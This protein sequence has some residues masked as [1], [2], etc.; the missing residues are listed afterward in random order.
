MKSKRTPHNV[1]HIL[2]LTFFSISF[3]LANAASNPSLSFSCDNLTYGGEIGHDH[4][5]CY[6]GDTPQEL[7][8]LSL[9]SGGSGEIEY[10]WIMTTE[11]PNEFISNW[12]SI[13]GSIHENYQPEAIYET[14]WF[15]RCAR[16]STCNEYIVES[17]WV[18]VCIDSEPPNFLYLPE[19]YITHCNE[20]P[21]FSEPEYYD[22]CSGI[23]GATHFDEVVNRGCEVDYT[24][25]WIVTD[26]CGK[27]NVTSQTV[28]TI[29][30]ES[31]NITLLPPYGDFINGDTLIYE[32]SFGIFFYV[33]DVLVT[34][35]CDADPEVTFIDN[36]TE[37]ENCAEDGY[38]RFLECYWVA[39]D[40]CG[41]ESK[42]VLYIYEVDTQDPVFT[43]I[44][45]DDEIECHQDPIFGTPEYED[46]C[47]LTLH[48][49]ENVVS[50]GDNCNYTHTKTWTVT[51]DCG[52]HSTAQQSI[53]TYDNEAPLITLSDPFQEVA[54]GDTLILQCYQLQDI[55]DLEATAVDNCD[56]DPEIKF[57]DNFHE[58]DDCAEDGYIMKMYCTWTAIDDCGNES[59]LSIHIYIVDTEA[60]VFSSIPDDTTIDCN[61]DPAFVEP[62]V[63]DDCDDDVH[64][65]E[66]TKMVEVNCKFKYQRTWTATDDCGNSSRVIQSIYFSDE[67]PPEILELLPVLGEHCGEFEIQYPVVSDH[68][69]GTPEIYASIDTI[70][71]DLFIDLKINWTVMDDCGNE[72]HAYQ[73]VTLPCGDDFEFTGFEATEMSGNRVSLHWVVT[74]EDEASFYNVEVSKDGI[75]FNSTNHTFEARGESYLGFGAYAVELND[76]YNGR[77]FYRIKYLPASS[78]SVLSEM[79]QVIFDFNNNSIIYPNPFV[80]NI[81]IEFH[82][83]S[84]QASTIYL[85]DTM[86]SLVKQFRVAAY[87]EL[88]PIDMN[89][90]APGTY[91][92]SYILN[93]LNYANRVVKLRE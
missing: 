92:L 12:I 39:V 86:G 27:E 80:D 14:T 61:E 20:E 47:D 44:P 93:G 17:N 35:N 41:N 89:D 54:H 46:N 66:E 87:T 62:E 82:T 90:V 32:C 34:D 52:N 79:D 49:E 21:N 37:S 48:L 72:A 9:P 69:D 64:I 26:N 77:S 13:P 36:V 68:C 58:S 3:N 33:E 55:Y 78:G 15:R 43:H 16:R 65:T 7:V 38:I 1:L 29:D 31:P 50:D 2:Y 84:D 6:P 83:P 5:V 88:Y 40:D 57:D 45:A 73:A 75:D 10:I 67:D 19:N 56:A 63:Y 59:V 18:K 11:D 30:N 91:L 24:R 60:P 70:Y 25:T 71:S 74:N 42:F 51:D 23:S 85:Y 53:Y 8:N 22:D 81:N 28:T 76:A 4:A